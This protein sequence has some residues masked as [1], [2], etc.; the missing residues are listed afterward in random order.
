MRTLLLVINAFICIITLPS[1]SLN[2]LFA[3]PAI[4]IDF[5]HPG[6]TLFNGTIQFPKL[7]RIPDVRV[8]WK[9]YRIKCERNDENQKTTF[10]ITDEGSQAALNLL[11]TEHIQ[12]ETEQNNVKYLKVPETIAHRFYAL[13]L[14]KAD[15]FL[16]EDQD[17]T[18]VP[19]VS[20]HI[21]E[22]QVP[23][24]MGI[25]PDNTVIICLDPLYIEKVDGGDATTLPMIKVRSDILQLVGSEENLHEHTDELLLSLLDCD[26]IHAAMQQEIRPRYDKKLILALNT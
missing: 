26:T 10:T 18:Q 8:Y 15:S 2:Q 4:G 6:K 16:T 7:N 21:K 5:R 20:W 22:L 25:I 24:E 14:T 1:Y 19:K 9:G 12:F 13:T 23:L 3:R 11:F 17:S